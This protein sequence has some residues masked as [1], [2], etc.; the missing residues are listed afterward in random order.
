M[1]HL[2]TNSTRAGG[3]RAIVAIIG[4]SRKPRPNSRSTGSTE[5]DSCE[6]SGAW[7]R[8]HQSDDAN[9]VL[10]IANNLSYLQMCILAIFGISSSEV[11]EPESQI[12]TVGT[13]V[14]NLNNCGG[15]GLAY[16]FIVLVEN[17]R[18]ITVPRL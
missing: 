13:I 11:M 7:V 9:T 4:A 5:P 2:R 18:L 3:G 8:N 15:V 17:L 12:Q 14:Y 16:D 6:P 10:S 1:R